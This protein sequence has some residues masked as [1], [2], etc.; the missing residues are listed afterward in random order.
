MAYK[1]SGIDMV[2]YFQSDSIDIKR[3]LFIKLP[4]LY[5]E[6]FD[7]TCPEYKYDL[8]PADDYVL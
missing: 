3:H 6:W 7:N 1:I 5:K 2:N 8:D 4:H